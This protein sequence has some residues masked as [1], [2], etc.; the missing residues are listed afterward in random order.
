MTKTVQ[1]KN[2]IT[3]AILDSTIATDDLVNQAVTGA[4]NFL[5]LDLDRLVRFA[6]RP[7][8]T[9]QD[10]E[11]K[12]K[13]L[14]L[15]RTLG[16]LFLIIQR[17]A[18]KLSAENEQRLAAVKGKIRSPRMQRITAEHLLNRRLEVLAV[19]KTT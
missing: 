19:V 14:K 9:R 16:Y 3:D 5:S 15:D 2:G 13:E 6:A 10:I 1:P 8:I 12:T 7:N 11:R 17:A 4:V 18:G